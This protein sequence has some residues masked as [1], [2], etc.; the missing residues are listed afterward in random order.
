MTRHSL[1]ETAKRIDVFD[2]RWYQITLE[3]KT[4]VDLP[5]VTTYLEAYPKGYGYEYWLMNTKDPYKVRDEAGQLGTNVH[6]M[7]ERTLR[8]ETVSY[9]EGQLQEWERFLSWCVWWKKYTAENKVEFETN[10]VECVVWS[11]DIQ[12]AGTVDLL[13][14][15]NDLYRVHDWKT[16]NSV[17]DT[18]FIQVSVYDFLV[19][20]SIEAET[21]P[22][23][24][25]QINPKL[26]KKGVRTYEVD[27][28]DLDGYVD[29]FQHT[30]SN[31]L[32]TNK[33]PKPK[34]RSY[35]SEISLDFIRDNEII[36]GV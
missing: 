29:D 28:E 17:E 9:V 23:I 30:K 11:T 10:G 27:A 8:G 35:P 13:A 18:A 19:R 34:Y 25:V 4:T 26:N 31:W 5:S 14:K 36:K 20:S 22:P 15:V 2:E 1:N 21:K 32:R 12:T 7:I 16:G 33:N 6:K 24:I 3:D